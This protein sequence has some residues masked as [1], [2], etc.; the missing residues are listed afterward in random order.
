MP[1]CLAIAQHDGYQPYTISFRY[2]QRHEYELDR[3]KELA[4]AFGVVSHRIIDIDLAQFGGS[5][6]TDRRLA[7]PEFRNLPWL[8]MP[9]PSQAFASA[10]RSMAPAALHR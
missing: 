2:G 10:V 6:L 1:T 7:V 4:K 5:A 8:P 9:A 3:A